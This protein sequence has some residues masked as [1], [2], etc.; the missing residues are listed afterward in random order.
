M[1][2]RERQVWRRSAN[3]PALRVASAAG[4]RTGRAP[5][6]FPHT[7]RLA[8]ARPDLPFTA[9][10]PRQT[11]PE[12]TKTMKRKQT[13]TDYALWAALPMAQTSKIEKR[14]TMILDPKQSRCAL[15]RRVLVFALVPATTALMTLAMLKPVARA[16]T[17]PAADT[18]QLLG[19]Q[20]IDI[21][22]MD[23]RWW[24]AA[25]QR[26]AG[27]VQAGAPSR[28][29]T[30]LLRSS[31][32]KN[33]RFAVRL[34]SA[35]DSR[36]VVFA[37]LGSYYPQGLS[38]P[39]KSADDPWSVCAA[40]PGSQK[41]TTLSVGVASGP[42]TET[43]NCPKTPGKVRMSRP[44]GEVF[45]TLVPD[46][47]AL[48]PA[49]AGDNLVLAEA[50]RKNAVL[51]VSDHFRCPSPL[52]IDKMAVLI[53]SYASRTRSGDAVQQLRH[54]SGNYERAVYGLDP[55]GRVVIRLAGSGYSE[56]DAEDRTKWVQTF[57]VPR[58]LLRRIASFRLVARPYQWTEF[59]DVALQPLPSAN[60]AGGPG[61]R[62]R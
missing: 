39:G 6:A 22:H 31:I 20:D 2:R 53:S 14:L 50:T 17:A 40:F 33:L 47:R 12:G 49:L 9:G 59:K 38:S 10:H 27:G 26:L 18:V 16:Q 13:L 36:S 48:T 19:V 37:P 23:H 30:D 41:T 5:M 15:T 28:T 42:W 43:V 34:P 8:S 52:P 45:F 4:A 44:A 29:A 21:H 61:H 1:P 25:G 57:S 11:I 51:M 24:N 62:E 60:A 7:V 32:D 46:R 54:D 35:V 55:S 3:R 56:I 58:P